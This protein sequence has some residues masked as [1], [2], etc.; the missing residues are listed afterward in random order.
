[1]INSIIAIFSEHNS[2]ISTLDYWFATNSTGICIISAGL[3]VGIGSMV[4]LGGLS[5]TILGTTCH[6][7]MD[8]LPCDD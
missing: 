8:L 2:V 7:F 5:N 6:C 3:K 1:M 4:R